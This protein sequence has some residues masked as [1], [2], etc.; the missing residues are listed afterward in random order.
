MKQSRH[1]MKC[2]PISDKSEIGKK[3]LPIIKFK[4]SSRSTIDELA[5][6][7]SIS[8]N[9]FQD[10]IDELENKRYGLNEVSFTYFDPD[11][12]EIVNEKIT[13][14]E[15]DAFTFFDQLYDIIS[16]DGELPTYD[17][18]MLDSEEEDEYEYEDENVEWQNV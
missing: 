6:K 5:V 15:L 16:T 10:Y 4:P 17:E 13:Q 7:F 8:W 9:S 14:R 3:K 1:Y 12:C 2:A 11:T 18:L